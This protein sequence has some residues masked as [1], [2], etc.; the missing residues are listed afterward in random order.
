VLDLLFD[1]ATGLGLDVVRYTIPASSH[2]AASQKRKPGVREYSLPGLS[3]VRA[4][5]RGAS[6]RGGRDW[7]QDAEQRKALLGARAEGVEG[8]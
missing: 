8:G 5:G 6:A 7:R 4:S 2:P 1:K 3:G